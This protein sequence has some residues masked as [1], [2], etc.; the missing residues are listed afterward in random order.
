MIW[1]MLFMLFFPC[2]AQAQPW[3]AAPPA[4]GRLVMPAAYWEWTLEAARE[5]QVSPYVIQG[6]M[7]IESRYKPRATSG[8]GTC[9]GLMQLNRD[10]ARG[11]GVDPWN[12]RENIHGGAQVLSRL[13]RKYGG[14]LK[15]VA[16][17]YHG[18][19]CPPAYVREVLRAIKQARRGR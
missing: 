1:I 9:I 16:R 12:P 3:P 15:R 14:D 10:V 8:R 4:I 5:H 7:A 19:G 17:A 2:S 11:L 6:F 13:M 18:P